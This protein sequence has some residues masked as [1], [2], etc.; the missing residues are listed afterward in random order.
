MPWSPPAGA[1]TFLSHEKT[2]GP[3]KSE[4]QRHCGLDVI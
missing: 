3:G 4:A 2:L 1:G